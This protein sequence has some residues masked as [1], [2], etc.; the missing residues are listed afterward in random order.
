L[1]NR[2]VLRRSS[3]AGLLPNC[4]G[5]SQPRIESIGSLLTETSQHAHEAAG[6]RLWANQRERIQRHL[7]RLGITENE[8]CKQELGCDIATMG[9]RVHLAKGWDDYERNRRSQGDNGQYGLFYGLSLIHIKSCLA[10]NAGWSRIHSAPEEPKL[11]STKCQF[12]TGE[13]PSEIRKLKSGAVSTI[14]TSPPYWPLKQTYGG[15]GIGYEATVAEYLGDFVTV[16][17]DARPVLNDT[18]TLWI[19]IG[20][21][22]PR[23]A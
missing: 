14:I 13:A 21:S 7:E 1:L 16:M 18:G 12:I 6:G 3:F 17:H 20:D 10:I 15:G 19:V 22:Y 4:V 11:D 5:N 8:W 9:R 23:P 2:L